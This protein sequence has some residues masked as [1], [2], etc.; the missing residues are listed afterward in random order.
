MTSTAGTVLARRDVAGLAFSSLAY[1]PGATLG[2]HVH[3]LPYLSFVGAGSYS[4]QVGGRTRHCGASTLLIHPA[5]ERHANQFHE[6]PVRLLRV[7]ASQS[8]VLDTARAMMT[9]RHGEAGRH[10]CRRMLQEL[11][12][13]DDVTPLALHGLLLELLLA[14]ARASAPKRAEPAWLLRVDELLQESFDTPLSLAAVATHAGVHPVHLAR[15]YRQHRRQTVGER[16]RDLR[17]EHACRWLATT[18]DSIADIA[19]R[20]GFADQSHLARLMRRRLGITPS[21]YRIE[22]S[23]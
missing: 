17:L 14:L 19:L 4:E 22:R 23:R 15:T 2:W 10:I 7:E 18:G 9:P 6:R 3:P 5:G 16:I 20:C 21:R 1:E 8:H 13:P 12:A 11:H